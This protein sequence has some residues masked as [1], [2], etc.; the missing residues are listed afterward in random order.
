MVGELR[1]RRSAFFALRGML[2]FVIIALLF[3]HHAEVSPRLWLLSIGF[4]ASDLLFLFLPLSWFGKAGLS[5]V[6]FLMD[7]AAVSF[8]LYFVPAIDPEALLL[9]YLAVFMGA[10]GGNLRKSVAIAA[11]VAALYAWFHLGREGTILA[12]PEA[13]LKIP[14]F[15][16]TSI[17]SGYL[18][19]ELRLNRRQRA[20]LTEVQKAKDVAEASTRAKSEFLAHMSHEIRTPMNGIMG[21]TDLLLD[22]KLNR[23]Q[24]D[25]L[26]MI[27]TSADSLL[28][29]INDILD[30]SKIEAGK[31]KLDDLNFDLRDSLDETLRMFAVRAHQKGLEL[32]CTVHP[33]VPEIVRG[34]PARIRQ[35]LVNLLGNAI[36]F[37]ERGEVVLNVELNT[38]DQQGYALHFAIRDTGIGITSEQQK[39][40]FEAFEQGD[41]SAARRYGG[42]GLGLTISSR[43]VGMMGGRIWVESEPGRGSTFHFTARLGAAVPVPMT[44]LPEIACLTDLRLLVVDDNASNRLF[45]EGLLTRWG[46]RP[47]VVDDGKAALAALNRA[48]ESGQPFHLVLT[49]AQMP[50]MDGFE[51]ANLINANPQLNGVPVVMLT[52]T[53]QPADAVLCRQSGLAAYLTKPIR[54]SE[55]RAAIAQ[56][57]GG[58]SSESKPKLV[59]RHSLRERKAAALR[60]LLAEDNV[61]N[62]TLASRLLERSGHTVVV[63]GTGREALSAWEKQP[64][65]LALMDVQMPEMD[66]LE[67]TAAI[68][69]KEKDTGAHLPIIA[70][71]AHAMQQDR[72]RCLQVGMDGYVSKPI[73]IDEL[74]QAIEASLGSHADC[75]VWAN[76]R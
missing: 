46:M 20:E 66:G 56:V 49:D 59:T 25:Y 61:V 9:Y 6:T 67:A 8:F 29:I 30:F 65:D 74:L 34:D 3:F 18:V 73:H 19:Q 23:E 60:I 43:L 7:M 52:S 16:V 13:L 21:M 15:F 24:R 27:K 68:R 4:L 76:G 75:P 50:E 45:L 64:F 11:V 37:T 70:M 28:G 51:L 54:Q 10:L 32:V 58:D 26:G 17:T 41:K 53:G 2:G 5:F 47:T 31:L 62:Q 22:T 1:Q 55:L 38:R 36:K 71:T 12:D 44:R 14:L 63:T 48:R 69:Q 39:S 35:V 33:E 42:T 57:L 40:I 72:E